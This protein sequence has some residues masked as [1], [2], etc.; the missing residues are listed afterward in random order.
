MVAH[1]LILQVVLIFHNFDATK[2]ITATN[3]QQ[4]ATNQ[5]A[6]VDGTGKNMPPY[7]TVNVWKRIA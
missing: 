7:L 4:T 5:E 3:Q 6:G 2:S 1:M